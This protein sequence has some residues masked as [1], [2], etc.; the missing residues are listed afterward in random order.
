MSGGGQPPGIACDGLALPAA[1]QV[2][3]QRRRAGPVE[4]RPQM[5]VPPVSLG[6][7]VAVGLPPER[8]VGADFGSG[9][10]NLSRPSSN[11]VGIGSSLL[12]K[13]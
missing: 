2:L 1:A 13:Y 11:W 8:F 10:L 9:R 3:A 5:H 4:Q 7:V 6:E 12:A